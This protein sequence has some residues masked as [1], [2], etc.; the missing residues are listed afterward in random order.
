ME[1][2]LDSNVAT[3][4]GHFVWRFPA[5]KGRAKLTPTLRVEDTLEQM[6]ES[7]STSFGRAVAERTTSDVLRGLRIH[8]RDRSTTLPHSRLSLVP[9]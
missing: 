8:T 7:N 6:F 1:F 9:K 4:R 2:A 5:L 3:R